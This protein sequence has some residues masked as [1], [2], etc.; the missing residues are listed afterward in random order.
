MIS[1][2]IINLKGGVGKS[3]TACNLAAELAAKSKSV[4]V[5][6]LDMKRGRPGKTNKAN[7][8]QHCC[9]YAR[10]RCT[11][12]RKALIMP[13]TALNCTASADAT[14]VNKAQAERTRDET[15]RSKKQDSRHH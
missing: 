5:V 6:D 4:L 13:G 15:R 3:V 11:R 1:I 14:R 10:L 7:S 12:R 2:A 8:R 9:L